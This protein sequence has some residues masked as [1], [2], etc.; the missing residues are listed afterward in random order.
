MWTLVLPMA[1]AQDLPA[2][3]ELRPDPRPSALQATIGP[4]GSAVLWIEHDTETDPVTHRLHLWRSDGEPVPPLEVT[5]GRVWSSWARDGAPW[6]TV[7]TKEG[8]TFHHVVDGAWVEAEDRPE[9]MENGIP[10]APEATID[11]ERRR[12]HRWTVTWTN[13]EDDAAVRLRWKRGKDW[14]LFDENDGRPR[15]VGRSRR[16]GMQ[17]RSVDDRPLDV[18]RYYTE[19]RLYGAR[20]SNLPL[21]VGTHPVALVHDT[22]YAIDLGDRVYRALVAVDVATGEERTVFA[23]DEADVVT[24]S[25]HPDTGAPDV[26]LLYEPIPRLVAVPGLADAALEADLA[27]VREAVPEGGHLLTLDRARGD[28]R[29]HV[30]GHAPHVGHACVHVDRDTRVIT[31]TVTSPASPWE[32]PR[33]RTWP[34]VIEI[35]DGLSL[36]SYLVLP[37]GADEGGRPA[38]PLPTVIRVHGGPYAREHYAYDATRTWLANQGYAVLELNFRGSTYMGTD[39]MTG[40]DGERGRATQRDI[41]EATDWLVQE[42]IADPDRIALMGHSFGGFSTLLG[43]ARTPEHYACGVALAPTAAWSYR[44]VVWALPRQL[45]ERAPYTQLDGIDDPLLL[46]HGR[47]DRTLP[48]GES[49]H[50]AKVLAKRGSPVAYLEADDGHAL[51]GEGVEQV[52]A[53]ATARFLARCLGGVAPPTDPEAWTDAVSVEA[54][55]AL[56][57]L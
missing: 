43:L 44:W 17:L 49:R 55:P 33:P 37:V 56:L 22:L 12:K 25:K 38:A 47:R 54:G 57:G 13:G 42:G 48:V 34:A 31:P 18:P 10:G 41:E 15:A 20:R 26:V 29:W 39:V 32:G 6:A 11:W 27:W 8:R 21:R 14:V 35:S 46:V 3:P 5:E 28:R 24:V 51:V 9:A 40:A 52:V 2:W 1:A 53:E 23:S 50:V 36:H 7:I 19:A 16:R 4:D 45:K 30:C